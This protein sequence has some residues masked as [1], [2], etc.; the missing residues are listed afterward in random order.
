MALSAEKMKDAV[1]KA[2]KDKKPDTAVTANK[3][4]GDEVLKNIVDTI[5]VTYA[6][7]ATNEATGATDPIIA[8]SAKVSGSGTLTPSTT[9]AEMLIKLSTLI[10][11]L[12]I[13]APDGFE[14][15]SLKFNP[16]GVLVAVMALENTP[17]LAMTNLC[18]QIVASLKIV[19]INPTPVSGKH[20]LFTG[21]TTGM[22]IA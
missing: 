10:K 12:T 15:A 6:W 19:F 9:F 21:A 7:A 13:E 22:V 4:F 18:T 14:V 2:M 5:D 11:G 20:G 16:V 8:F 17:E 1:M 3:I